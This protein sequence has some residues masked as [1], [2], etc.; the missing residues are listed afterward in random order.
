[1]SL[2]IN[3]ARALSSIIQMLRSREIM[4]PYAELLQETAIWCALS[5]AW[6]CLDECSNP[7]VRSFGRL[8]IE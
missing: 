8:V 7:C 2:R 5:E 4:A 3:N 1:V 6:G